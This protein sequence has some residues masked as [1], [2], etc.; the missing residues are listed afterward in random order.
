MRRT[1]VTRCFPRPARVRDNKESRWNAINHTVKPALD[2]SLNVNPLGAPKAFKRSIIKNY[3]IL[4][5]RPDAQSTAAKN[6]LARYHGVSPEN[7]LIGSGCTELLYLAARTLRPRKVL[8]PMPAVTV[9]AEACKS[10]G[11]EVV[12]L[13]TEKE[14]EFDLDADR[15]IYAAAEAGADLVMLCNP[16]NPTSRIIAKAE[17]LKILDYCQE[18]G[19]YVVVDEAYADFVGADISTAK[20]INRYANLVI[21]R[22]LANYFALPGLRFAYALA[23]DNLTE[24]LYVNRVPDTV[25]TLALTAC[26]TLLCDLKYIRQTKAWLQTE[27]KRFFRLLSTLGGV[28]AYKPFANFIFTELEHIPAATLCERL[29]SKGITVRDCGR[30]GVA[31]G[32]YIRIAIKDK[33]SNDKFLDGLSRCLL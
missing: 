21:I 2:Y 33:K 28:I 4:S 13:Y 1:V 17:M 24:L 9:Y 7:V 22:T 10:N 20:Q 30:L 12:P 6:A 15:L 19:I 18:K 5:S 29:R 14:S 27:P 25:G 8:I 11:C 3:S 23:C 32:K 31:E 26:E 16:G